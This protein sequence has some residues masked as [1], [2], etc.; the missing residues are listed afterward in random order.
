MFVFTL[1]LWKSKDDNLFAVRKLSCY[2]ILCIKRI[3]SVYAIDIRKRVNTLFHIELELKRIP[4]LKSKVNV[5]CY[6]K[7]I[8][9]T[10][11]RL[12]VVQRKTIFSVIKNDNLK[13]LYSKSKYPSDPEVTNWKKKQYLEILMNFLISRMISRKAKGE[14][15]SKLKSKWTRTVRTFFL[16]RIT[17][18]KAHIWE[19]SNI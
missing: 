17:S 6:P 4:D 10:S 1:M 18:H 14:N 2:T 3:L 16:C 5:Q 19:C 9:I 15:C 7:L 13:I 8:K 11:M 12:H